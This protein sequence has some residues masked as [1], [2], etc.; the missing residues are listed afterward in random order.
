MGRPNSKACSIKF[1]QSKACKNTGSVT[2]FYANQ[3]YGTGVTGIKKSYITK[4]GLVSQK[5][6]ASVFE[7][8]AKN[9]LII[10]KFNE[11]QGLIN[12][13][14]LKGVRDVKKYISH[15]NNQKSTIANSQFQNLTAITS[16]FAK[17]YVQ[18][19]LN[20][21]KGKAPRSSERYAQF[22]QSIQEFEDKKRN[23]PL[24]QISRTYL[25]EMIVFLGTPRE[26]VIKV[27][28]KKR[29]FLQ[30]KKR[31]KNNTTLNRFVNDFWQ[32][33][34]WAE[35]KYSFKFDEE[36]YDRNLLLNAP[37][38]E[39]NLYSLSPIQLS[40][41]LNY[42][43]TINEKGKPLTKRERNARLRAK[44]LFIFCCLT[45][46]SYSC[47]TT[48]F[49]KGNIIDGEVLERSRIKTD[50]DYQTFLTPIAKAIFEKYSCDFRGKFSTV[51]RTNIILRKL[52]KQV[53]EFNVEVDYLNWT[54]FNNHLPK[55]MAKEKRI[56]WDVIAFHSSR[57]TFVTQVS[58]LPNINQ[59]QLNLLVGWNPNSKSIN[60]YVNK[61]NINLKRFFSQIESVLLKTND[62]ADYNG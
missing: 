43:P 32:F 19:R 6:P 55:E 4:E 51:Q 14:L 23:I 25:E 59:I 60:H 24:S 27:I 1:R 18:K 21:L 39:D 47:A 49:L 56:L 2:I 9:D 29:T 38:P 42:T 13:V 57:K 46:M 34:S 35:R 41:L 50:V 37:A 28:Q 61:E 36:V 54:I 15:H 26:E 40:G 12:E 5:Y 30:K 48:L 62:K 16:D 20:S 10:S 52:L 3:H 8:Q 17:I 22:L 11:V 31:C 44:D 45:G 53:P 33:L 7:I 58:N